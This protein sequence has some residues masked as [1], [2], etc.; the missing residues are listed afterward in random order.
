MQQP[1]NMI[2]EKDLLYIT[3]MLSWNLNASKKANFYAEQ[4][5]LPEIKQAL[6]TTAKMHQRHYQQILSHLNTQPGN[7]I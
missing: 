3:D 4:C 6:D 2:S 5:Q 7:V 1:P